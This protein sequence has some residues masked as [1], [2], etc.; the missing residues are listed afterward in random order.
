MQRR[1]PGNHISWWNGAK[2]VAA[3]RRAGFSDVYLSGQAQSASPALRD[4]RFFDVTRPT[5]SVY[6]E[7][8]K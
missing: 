7:G 2:L 8:R 5:T 6:V 3:L 4:R 1:H